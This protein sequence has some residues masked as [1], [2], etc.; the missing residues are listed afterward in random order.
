[1][2]RFDSVTMNTFRA[3][4]QEMPADISAAL[5]GLRNQVERLRRIQAGPLAFSYHVRSWSILGFPDENDNKATRCR[6]LEGH[7]VAGEHQVGYARFE[8]YRLPG[9][10]TDLELWNNCDNYSQEASDVAEAVLSGWPA[11]VAEAGVLVEFARLWVNPDHARH[12]EWAEPIRKLIRRR[13]GGNRTTRAS[14]LLLKPYPLELEGNCS[15]DP[16]LHEAMLARRTRAMRHLY[17]R[18]LDVRP[19]QESG[20]MYKTF[21]GRAPAPTRKPRRWVRPA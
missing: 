14:I 16:S 7:F 5:T 11:S 15:L 13:W 17:S 19:L 8:E 4:R 9:F 21:Y 2:P 12:S 3:A 18:L 6:R 20:W 10:L 1:M